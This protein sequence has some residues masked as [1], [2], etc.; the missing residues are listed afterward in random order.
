MNTTRRSL[1]AL[2]AS[3]LALAF[4]GGCASSMDAGDGGF[5]KQLAQDSRSR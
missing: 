4:L 5:P 1:R 3:L 2:A